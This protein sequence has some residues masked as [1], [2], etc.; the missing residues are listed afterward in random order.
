MQ[1]RLQIVVG[2]LARCSAVADDQHLG[3]GASAAVGT[4]KRVVDDHHVGG[5]ASRDAVSESTSIGSVEP[6]DSRSEVSLLAMSSLPRRLMRQLSKLVAPAS[7]ACSSKRRT[8]LKLA[9][10][11]ASTPC[12][13]SGQAPSGVPG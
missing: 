10:Q 1:C 11:A 5:K 12:S 2:V 9:A 8:S 6:I 7:G 4:R 3:D 13:M